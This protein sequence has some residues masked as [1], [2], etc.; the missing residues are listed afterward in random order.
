MA[1]VPC[2]FIKGKKM[3]H[4]DPVA[5][6][7][8]NIAS[9]RF[10]TYS[11]ETDS[12]GAAQTAFYLRIVQEAAGLHAAMRGCSI[13]DLHAEGKTWVITRNRIEIFGYTRWNE[14][15]HVNTWA[16]EPIRLHL[17]R[18]VEGYATDGSPLFRAKTLWAII[19]LKNSRPLRPQE[20]NERIGLVKDPSR[21][22][23]MNLPRPNIDLEALHQLGTYK[24]R[25]TYL[26]TD[27]NQHINNVSYL[28]WVLEALPAE[29]RTTYKVKSADVLYQKQT[30]LDDE[31]FVHTYA[32]DEN[33]YNEETPS[34]ISTIVR[35]TG[36]DEEEIVFTAYTDWKKRS[37]F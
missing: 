33:G 12:L 19:D 34:L 23:D 18:I 31:L 10:T 29:F 16:Q 24:P 1:A 25:V 14:Q 22:I 35:Q 15:I 5:I 36:D 21:I 37:R 20:M 27:R 17:P 26:D 8:E 7:A 6:S 13:M 11:F 32:T 4:N 3:N 9:L 28:S 30:F 2:G